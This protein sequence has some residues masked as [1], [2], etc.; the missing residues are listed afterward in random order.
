MNSTFVLRYCSFV[1]ICNII[2]FVIKRPKES[3]DW[4]KLLSIE[5]ENAHIKIIIF[6]IKIKFRNPFIDRLRDCCSI[7]NIEFLEQQQNTSFPHPIGI[8]IS[9]NAK[10]G[11]NCTIFQN[12]T[13]GSWKGKSPIV[14]DNVKIFA[15]SVIFGEISIGNNVIIGAGSVVNKSVPENAVVCGNPAKVIKIN[16]NK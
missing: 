10:I 9:P 4:M 15:N 16:E 11:K 1:K 8:V 3:C 6:G 12:V 7:E 14:G 2:A 13:I 5:K